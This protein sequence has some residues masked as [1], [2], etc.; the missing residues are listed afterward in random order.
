MALSETR[1]GSVRWDV[2]GGGGDV[3]VAEQDLHDPGV[4]AAF[5]QP[6][7]ITVAQRVR[8][9]SPLDPRRAG[10]VLEGAAQHL[11]IGRRAGTIGE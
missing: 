1:V 4:D 11:L 3:D 5:E 6:R 10:G 7:R 9:D 8:R 2:D